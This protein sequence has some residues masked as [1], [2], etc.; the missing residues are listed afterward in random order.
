M[1]NILFT[2][3]A[4]GLFTNLELPQ[5][6]EHF[7]SLEKFQV[8]ILPAYFENIK[9]LIN[10]NIKN[11]NLK[12]HFNLL[13]IQTKLNQELSISKSPL[14]VTFLLKIKEQ[15]FEE[16][17]EKNAIKL[18]WTMAYYCNVDLISNPIFEESMKNMIKVMRN[19]SNWV[20]QNLSNY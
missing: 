4:S 6:S 2:D 16:L 18:A 11:L 19:N 8:Q 1:M 13:Y 14:F 9:H 10:S 5:I 20:N 7:I 17:Q 3:K 12:T 15:I